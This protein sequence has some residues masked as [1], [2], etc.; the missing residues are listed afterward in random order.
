[1]R[2]LYMAVCSID[3]AVDV[4]KAADI[5][6]ETGDLYLYKAPGA[7]PGG[8]EKADTGRAIAGQ[9]GTLAA[10]IVCSDPYKAEARAR[11]I[12]AEWLG[13][14][15]KKVLGTT[16]SGIDWG[17]GTIDRLPDTVHIPEDVARQGTDAVSGYLS[18]ISGSAVNGFSLSRWEKAGRP[19][20]FHEERK[21]MQEVAVH[22]YPGA[23]LPGHTL[24]PE[25]MN[26]WEDEAADYIYDHLDKVRF[27][28]PQLDFYDLDLDVE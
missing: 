4:K 24:S 2:H 28:E 25:D 13:R 18:T 5:L 7:C 23:V 21:G 14:A 1:M 11:E 26:P 16:A 8:M 22:A 6:G 12:F 19:V 20:V 15:L 10:S 17:E 3:G 27:E 9:D